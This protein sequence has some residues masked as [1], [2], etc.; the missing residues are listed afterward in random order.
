MPELPDLS[1]YLDCIERKAL[2]APLRGLRIGNPFVLRSVSPPPAE[3]AGRRLRGTAR[4]GKRLALRFDV[5][6]AAL[7][8]PPSPHA[9]N[10]LAL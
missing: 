10:R 9:R 6:P 1:V 7:S 2:G 4:I 5:R 8:D 3:L